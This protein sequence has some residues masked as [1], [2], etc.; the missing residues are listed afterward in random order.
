MATKD[1]RQTELARI[2]IL[3][4]ALIGTR[5]F[6]AEDYANVV[7]VHGRQHS[8]KDLD[9][10]GRRQVI[11]HLQARLKAID[12]KHPKLARFQ[13]QPKNIG[14]RG[15]GELEKIEALLTD[16]GLG[17]NYA[18]SLAKR[19][20]RRDRVQLCA[21]GQLVGIVAALHK[22]ALKRLATDLEQ[23]LGYSWADYGAHLA[24]WLFDFDTLHRRF[25]AYPE[26]MSK[27]LRWC[28][29]DLAVVCQWPVDQ[30]KPSC[31]SGCFQVSLSQV[32]A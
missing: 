18:H 28:R 10:H 23:L 3:K 7:W 17:W 15:R 2:H 14:A 21:D 29:G 24:A 32:R 16:A 6:D 8:S 19:M 27:V 20:Y 5:E 4:A 30:D 22:A 12:P 25:D 26:V 31:C 1:P 11:E 9:G 13:G